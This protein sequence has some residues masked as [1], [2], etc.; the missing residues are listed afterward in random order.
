[1]KR[2][3]STITAR[4]SLFLLMALIGVTLAPK[5]ASAQDAGADIEGTWQGPLN[6]QGQELR[7]VFHITADADGDGWSATMDS[8]DQGATGIPVGDVTISGDSVRLE[9]PRIYGEFEGVLA[10]GEIDGAWNQGM[11]S[12]PLTLM[13]VDPEEAAAA[14]RPQEPVPPLP[15]RSVDVTFSGGDPGVTLAGTITLPEGEG[16]HPGVVLVS[17]SGPQDR[18]ETIMGHKPFLV[19]AD[20]LTRQ[21]IAVLRY[22]D[23]GFGESTGDYSAAALEDF[24][25]DAQSAVEFLRERD[26]VAGGEVGLLG[27]SEGG[28]VA[29]RVAVQTDMLDFAVLLAG[30]SAP[31]AEVLARQ[32]RLMLKALGM[33]QEG[34]SEYEQNMLGA[35]AR[36]LTVPVDRPVPDSVRR[37]LQLDFEDAARA[38]SVSDRAV[39]GPTDSTAFSQVLTRLVD[40]LTSP[41]LRSFLAYD[42]QADLE[43][44]DIPVLALFGGKDLQVPAAQNVQAM[45]RALAGNEQATVRT[46]P[47][48]NHLFQPAESGMPSEYGQIET[49]IAPKVLEVVGSWI[50]EHT[51]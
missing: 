16:P 13:R 24:T 11:G 42:P 45:R 19:I 38:M 46:F 28:Y 26:A 20:Y 33:S 21:G 23:R 3:C 39:Y 5:P 29:P 36:L 27:H 35:I 14:P 32:N 22:D 48:V 51:D 4:C 43:Q 8:P 49:T 12:W 50:R 41:G 25:A 18:N 34:A 7:L 6:V 37:A 47:D 31:G 9:I 1:M 44:I 17:G 2:C 40:Q 15:Y 10:N 30:P